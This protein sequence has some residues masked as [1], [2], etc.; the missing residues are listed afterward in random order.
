VD[1][2]PFKIRHITRGAFETPFFREGE[3]VEDRRL[4]HR[5][6]LCWSPIGRLSIVTIALSLTFQPQF[7]I[8]CLRRSIRQGVDYFWSKF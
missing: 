8:E 7:A 2:W 5:K 6:E 3:V 1:M 4:Y